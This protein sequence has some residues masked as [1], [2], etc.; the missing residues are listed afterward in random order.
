MIN[1]RQDL[2]AMPDDQR[3]AFLQPLWAASISA[4]GARRDDPVFGFTSAELDGIF[5]AAPPQPTP[6]EVSTP[7]I[8]RKSLTRRQVRLG[9]LHHGLLTAVESALLDNLAMRIYYEDSQVFWRDS[10]MIAAMAQWL[11]KDSEWLDAFFDM[12]FEAAI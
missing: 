10:P 2:G 5:G 12:D 8:E 3:K 1:T 11:G 4:D 7:M 6:S 9:L